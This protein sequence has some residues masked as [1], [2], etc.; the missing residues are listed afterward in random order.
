MKGYDVM[1]KKCMVVLTIAA[2]LFS[3]AG[4]SPKNNTANNEL[5][6]LTWDG[7]IP[8]DI[9]DGFSESE[10][11]KI[12]ISN[13]DSNEEML[14]KISTGNAGYDLVIGSDYIV[15]IARK[16]D[17]L[18]ELDK[19]KIPNYENLDEGYLSKFY[20][21]ENKYTVPYSAG[22]PVILYDKSKT[23]AEINGYGDLWN[24][25]LKGKVLL[26]DDARNIVGI[27]L[28][29][30]GYSM[31]TTEPEKLAEAKDKLAELKENIHH[32]NYTNP[33]ESLISGDV[34]IAYLFSSQ[35][36][37]ALEARP[38][39]EVVFP[40]EGIGFGIDC[41]FI[42][43][44]AQNT[45]NAH[46]FL[47]YITDAENGAKITEQIMYLSPNKAAREFLPDT[48]KNNPIFNIPADK[49]KNS[50]FIQ[51]I[52]SAAEEYTKIWTEFKQ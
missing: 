10:N 36:Y 49:L 44:G 32:L 41:W 15:D 17:L 22:S 37:L 40:E 35:A 34:D 5:N 16:Q 47:N 51:D 28:K 8:Q 39:L 23:G 12:N 48:I 27:T 46:K 43:K 45:D 42:P 7:Y 33:H 25:E 2:I 24:K 4:C 1:L 29:S 50:E 26:I 13:F 21:P 6:I 19:S 52:G 3:F 31:N 20:D 30:L 18:V 11:I 14:A 9:L 38:E